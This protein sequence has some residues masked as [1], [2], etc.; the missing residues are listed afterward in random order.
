MASRYTDRGSRPQ[1]PCPHERVACLVSC[2]RRRAGGVAGQLGHLGGT[3]MP[4]EQRFCPDDAKAFADHLAQQ[5]AVETEI[6]CGAPSRRLRFRA[7]GAGYRD[8]MLDRHPARHVQLLLGSPAR[9][10]RLVARADGRARN[11]AAQHAFASADRSRFSDS[12][13]HDDVR[14]HVLHDNDAPLCCR[15]VS[16]QR[17]RR[18]TRS[19]LGLRTNAKAGSPSRPIRWC[20]GAELACGAIKPNRGRVFAL[21]SCD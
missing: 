11:G 14:T 12:E 19:R 9:R 5:P 3:A 1:L 13:L 16:P 21:P 15:A 8:T 6:R 2:L 4:L 7:I 17:A 18:H 10:T 20:G